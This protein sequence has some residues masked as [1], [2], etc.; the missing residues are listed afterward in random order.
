MSL[1]STI[2]LRAPWSKGQRGGGGEEG[3]V[4]RAATPPG[5]G[6]AG[7]ESGN[8]IEGGLHLLQIDFID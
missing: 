8:S 5:G 4:Q 6:G 3:T 1:G 7:G 2:S